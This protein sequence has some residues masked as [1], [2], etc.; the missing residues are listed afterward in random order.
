LSLAGRKLR[1]CGVEVSNV[2]E[3]QYEPDAPESRSRWNDLVREHVREVYLEDDGRI[4]VTGVLQAG[5]TS[6]PL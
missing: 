1:E 6:P 5:M 2:T 3:Q 4:T